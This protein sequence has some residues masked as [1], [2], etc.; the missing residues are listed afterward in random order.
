MYFVGSE[1]VTVRRTLQYEDILASPGCSQRVV[2]IGG[3]MGGRAPLH[4]A[5][6]MSNGAH[7]QLQNTHLG[8]LS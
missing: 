6:R 7:L 4:S 2:G 8:I 1:R 3:A 5:L